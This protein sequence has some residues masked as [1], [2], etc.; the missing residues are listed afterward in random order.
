[1]DAPTARSRLRPWLRRIG[2]V[3]KK[4]WRILDHIRRGFV[5]L[6]VL[7]LLL[8]GLFFAMCSSDD[9]DIPDDAVLVIAPKGTIVE[10]RRAATNVPFG[11]TGLGSMPSEVLLRDLLDTIEAAKQDDRIKVLYFD[12]SK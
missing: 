10:Q 12:L 9:V 8:G 1:M 7:T 5:N 3:L 4:A 2:A 6:V 11:P